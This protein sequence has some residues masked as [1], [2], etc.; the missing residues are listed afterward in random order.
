MVT[1]RAFDREHESVLTLAITCADG[2]QVSASGASSGSDSGS[3]R[4][5]AGGHARMAKQALVVRV[6]DRNDNAPVFALREYAREVQENAEPSAVGVLFETRAT[7][8]DEGPNGQLT[9][10]LANTAVG[11]ENASSTRAQRQ[12]KRQR[13]TGEAYERLFSVDEQTGTIRLREKLDHEAHT[14]YSFLVCARDAGEPTPLA[15]GAAVRVE[16][17]DVNDMAPSFERAHYVFNVTEGSAAT[18]AGTVIGRLRA[19]DCDRTH[20]NSH[21]RVEIEPRRVRAFEPADPALADEYEAT[22]KPVSRLPFSLTLTSSPP[23][24]EMLGAPTGSNGTLC[25]SSTWDMVVNG[26]LDRETVSR[27]EF[28]VLVLDSGSPRALSSSANISVHVLDVNDC[29]PE[30][31]RPSENNTLLPAFS[32]LLMNPGDTVYHVSATDRDLVGQPPAPTTTAVAG[33][34]GRLSYTLRPLQ[35]S[36]SIASS[37]AT[38]ALAA[39]RLEPLFTLNASSGELVVARRPTTADA[40]PHG[41]LV[42]VT[43]GLHSASI[44]FQ[45]CA[46]YSYDANY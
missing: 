17:V 38:A 29:A 11:C 23:T 6:R 30:F 8:A 26:E 5:A 7:D 33:S 39:E 12:R 28:A 40:G 14:S 32:A 42:E 10:Y 20:S 46:N 36:G 27:Y 4:S 45:V 2:G 31:K 41:W 34:A 44:Y 3:G 13:N 16:V 15:G 24:S 25:S 43:D 19:T 22:G 35:P 9:Y 18:L 37:A 21:L 1:A